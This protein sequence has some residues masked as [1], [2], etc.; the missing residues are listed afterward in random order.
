VKRLVLLMLLVAPPASA[1]SITLCG[2]TNQ[3]TCI[4]WISG[5][6]ATVEVRCP[7]GEDPAGTPTT[8]TMPPTWGGTGTP[9]GS[10]SP[11]PGNAL[12]VAQGAAVGRATTAAKNLL[13]GEYDT[14]LH[15][16][17]DNEC[18]NLFDGSKLGKSGHGLLTSYIVFRSGDG[19]RDAAQ[20]IPCA[21]NVAAWTRCC[22]HSPYVFICPQFA[23]L[24]SEQQTA[25]LIH[26]AMHVAGQREDTNTTVGAGDPPSSANITN[27][28]NRA[29]GLNGY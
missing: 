23:N 8:G 19:V 11:A 4:T 5:G 7:T 27:V 20:N 12:D 17:T 15:R 18:T 6:S 9:M 28:V 22:S 10:T 16:Y 25:T 3:C 1:A 13:L 29:C 26:E 14:E 24:T 2:D 21:G